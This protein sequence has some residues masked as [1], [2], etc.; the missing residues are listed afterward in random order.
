MPPKRKGAYAAA[1]YTTYVRVHAATSRPKMALIT[2]SYDSGTPRPRSMMSDYN[3]ADLYEEDIEDRSEAKI[4]EF[5]EKVIDASYAVS[6][7]KPLTHFLNLGILVGVF[8]AD[9]GERKIRFVLSFSAK[10]IWAILFTI[11]WLGLGA[12]VATYCCMHNS[13]SSLSSAFFVSSRTVWKFKN[14]S[15]AAKILREINFAY[16]GAF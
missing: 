11:L 13:T 7:L 16:C 10:L 3:E 9:S 5:E 12:G 4:R 6:P 1:Y 2:P 8:P 14:F 15:A